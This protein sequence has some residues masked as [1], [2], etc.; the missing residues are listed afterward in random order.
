[1]KC[2]ANYANS[3]LAKIEALDCG[4]NEAIQL[5]LA[6]FVAEGPGENIFLIKNGVLITPSEDA[7]ALYGITAQS[8]MAIAKNFGIDCLKRNLLREELFSADELFFTGTAAEITP[9]RE[10]DGRIIGNGGRG[11]VTRKIQEKFFEVVVGKD[12]SYYHWL[13]FI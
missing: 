2:S 10:V 12:T 4:Y 3:V 9:I 7:G 1:M 5:N 13:T 6:G 8:A 11:E